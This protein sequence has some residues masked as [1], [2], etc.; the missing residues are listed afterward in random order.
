MERGPLVWGSYI[1]VG[2]CLCL[3]KWVIVVFWLTK[4]LVCVAWPLVSLFVLF[5]ETVPLN[6]SDFLA[7]MTDRSTI[8]GELVKI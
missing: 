4:I 2:I 7:K 5:G 8:F 1:R 3:G 6:V